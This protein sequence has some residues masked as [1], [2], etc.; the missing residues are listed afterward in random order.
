VRAF[1]EAGADAVVL[2]PPPEPGIALDQLEQAATQ[3]RW[4]R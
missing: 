2:A 3:L 1:V 4:R